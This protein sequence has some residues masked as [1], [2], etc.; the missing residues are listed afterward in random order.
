[1]RYKRLKIAVYIVFTSILM[2]GTIDLGNLFNY[3]NQ[4]LSGY[5]N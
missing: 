2:S 1:M 5:I 4:G 3:V